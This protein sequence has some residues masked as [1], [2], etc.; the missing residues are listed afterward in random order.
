[1]PHKPEPKR[2]EDRVPTAYYG[3][4]QSERGEALRIAPNRNEVARPLVDAPHP[5]SDSLLLR[6]CEDFRP[7]R[8]SAASYD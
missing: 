6:N 2:I 8:L 4:P 7:Q 5:L 3:P 1:M